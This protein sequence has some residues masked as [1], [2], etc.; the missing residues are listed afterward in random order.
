MAFER[1]TDEDEGRDFRRENPSSAAEVL[2]PEEKYCEVCG[3]WGAPVA[4]CPHCEQEYCTEHLH[5]CADI[6]EGP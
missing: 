4:T 6:Q 3:D 1:W 5:I 2:E